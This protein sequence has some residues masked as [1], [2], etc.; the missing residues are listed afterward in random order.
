MYTNARR[1]FDPSMNPAVIVSEP[2]LGHEPA[3]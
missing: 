2:E 3:A 1:V